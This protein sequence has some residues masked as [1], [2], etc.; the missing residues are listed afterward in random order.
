MGATFES[1]WPWA[2]FAAAKLRG[3]AARAAAR[4]ASHAAAHAAAHG[5]GFGWGASARGEFP[6]FG[7]FFGP[8]GP[9]GRGAPWGKG[10][11][12]KGNV[13]AAILAL[14][15]EEPRNGYQIIQE[16]GERSG[17]AW[18]PS[19]GAV[20]PALQQLVDE[21]LIRAEE[22][23]GRRVHRLTDEGRAYVEAHADELRE[24]WAAMTPDYGEGVPEMFKQAAQTGAALMQIVHSG[25]PDQVARARDVLART[26]RDLYRILADDGED[27][28]D[29]D[30]EE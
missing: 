25:S 17:G 28:P 11:A 20:Y 12:R 19:P 2:A 3:A 18:R 6:G 8:G 21:G 1:E 27:V 7:G 23:A 26:R 22:G 29:D 24:P 15:A 10:K 30:R 4:A 16:I 5:R 9:W 13:R 14:L